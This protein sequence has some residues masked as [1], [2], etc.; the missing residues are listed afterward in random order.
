VEET[1]GNKSGR[2]RGSPPVFVVIVTHLVTQPLHGFR[3]VKRL[4]TF[5]RQAG[6]SVSQDR[7]LR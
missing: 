3:H 7:D 6:S 4:L 1:Y 5:K 2:I